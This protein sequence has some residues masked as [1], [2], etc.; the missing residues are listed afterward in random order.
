[1]NLNTSIFKAY[2]IRGIYPTE[3]QA[4]TVATIGR[5]CARMFNPG[6]IIIAYDIRHGSTELAHVLEES[7]LQEAA[8]QNKKITVKNIGLAT[9]PMFY[10]SVNHFNAPGGCMITAS[11][12]PSNYNGIKIVE[13]GAKMISGTKILEL[14]QALQN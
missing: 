11:H 13:E 3:I 9:T 2:D 8:L 10:F 14:V 5:A 4:E 7:I 1:M 6:E 12:N